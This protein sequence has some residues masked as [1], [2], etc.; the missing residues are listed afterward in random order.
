MNGTGSV[1]WTDSL[2][3]TTKNHNPSA[4]NDYVV[5]Q[6]YIL[7]SPA[8]KSFAFGGDSLTVSGDSQIKDK[9]ANN[10]T[11]TIPNL[12]VTGK[13]TIANGD[14][15]ALNKIAGAIDIREAGSLAFD[16]SFDNASGD[17]RKFEVQSDV[18]G[19]GSLCAVASDEVKSAGPY[20][21]FLGSLAGF[22]GKIAVRGR[23]AV[24]FAAIFASSLPGDPDGLTEDGLTVEGNSA[25]KF[26]TSGKLGIMRGVSLGSGA[27]EIYVAEGE[28]VQIDGFVTGSVGFRKTGKGTLALANV[29]PDLMGTVTVAEGTLQLCDVKETALPAADVTVAP[30]AVLDEHGPAVDHDPL[31]EATLT[32][33][34]VIADGQPHGPVLTVTDPTEGYQV[35]WSVDGG[36]YV[37]TRPTFTAPG[38]HTVFCR[39]SAT[40]YMARK[41]RTTVAIRA[42]RRIVATEAEKEDD[43]ADA[44]VAGDDAWSAIQ[45]VIDGC[46]VGDLVL[47]KA[48]TYLLTNELSF[49][50]SLPS[51]IILRSDDGAGNLAR[52]TTLFV[53]GYPATSNRLVRI[54]AP[55][56]VVDGFTLTNGF[57]DASC[58]GGAYLDSCGAGGGLRNCDVVCCT[59]WHEPFVKSNINNSKLGTG[60]GVYV[61]NTGCVSNCLIRGNT[62][63]AG[64][65]V[66]L[67]GTQ[68]RVFC[69]QSAAPRVTACTLV[70]NQI[71]GYGADNAFTGSA[72]A[73]FRTTFF[74]GSTIVSNFCNV[75][76]KGQFSTVGTSGGYLTISNCVFE[77]NHLGTWKTANLPVVGANNNNYIICVGTTFVREGTVGNVFNNS[78]EK[79]V[80][81]GNAMVDCLGS[82]GGSWKEY[83]NCLFCGNTNKLCLLGAVKAENCTFVNNLGAIF[84]SGGFKT[85]RIANCV[86][87]GNANDIYAVNADNA[88]NIVC[89][90]SNCCISATALDRRQG[91]NRSFALVATNGCNIIYEATKMKIGDLGFVAPSQRDFHLREGS[92]LLD[93]GMTL[94]WMDG[95]SDRDGKPRVVGLAPDIGCYERQ[96]GTIDPPVHFVRAVAT[97][98]DKKDE[99]ADAYVGLQAAA[100]AAYGETVYVKSGTYDVTEPVTVRSWGVSIVGEGPG[101][102]V[103]DGGLPARTN[104]IFTID[105]PNVTLK[106][107]TIQNGRANKADGG[108]VYVNA[109][110]F[111]MTNCVIRDCVGQNG[112]G[113]YAA[114]DCHGIADCVFSNNLST[115]YGAGAYF[116]MAATVKACDFLDGETK[117]EG[118]GCYCNNVYAFEDCVFSNNTTQTSGTNQK[119]GAFYSNGNY[120]GS[121]AGCFFLDNYA[122]EN[123]GACFPNGSCTFDDCQ[124][125]GNRCKDNDGAIHAGSVG[126]V[127]TVRGCYFSHNGGPS[128]PCVLAGGN[129]VVTNCVFENQTSTDSSGK[130]GII[131]R[132]ADNKGSVTRVIVTDCKFLNAYALYFVDEFTDVENCVFSNITAKTGIGKSTYAIRNSLFTDSPEPIRLASRTYENCTIVNNAGGAGVLKGDMP[133]LVNTVVAKSRPYTESNVRVSENFS[134]HKDWTANSIVLTNSVIVGGDDV[135]GPDGTTH[136][137]L[138]ALDE[139]GKSFSANPRFVDPV[140]GDWHLKSGS[141]LRDKALTL[142][143]MTDDATDLDGKPRRISS[144][145]KAYPDSLP[146]IGCYECDIPKPGFLLQVR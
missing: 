35:E 77:A 88:K 86:F 9:G 13:A 85:N 143:W 71:V 118:G 8:G 127:M 76:A 22:S 134:C 81:D 115:S 49:A 3:T 74:D 80:C 114:V 45:G 39:V 2:G 73:S 38:V 16:V 52:K 96:E 100:D 21:K 20:V 50:S 12:I 69:A 146:D 145:G 27:C 110:D 15:N 130:N 43:W 99:W 61:Y 11:V 53:G 33:V 10:S 131:G 112:G 7:R 94:D 68:E 140:N 65:G 64:G 120:L 29:S 91:T 63:F 32:G 89:L 119:G 60:G 108:G 34:D 36:A 28:T 14:A 111:A 1:G 26:E 142:D 83:R 24:Q 66:Y 44:T 132:A 90:I 126:N 87:Y 4:G 105:T 62:A 41:L 40:G 79:F 93:A 72:L 109:V 25:L 31:V 17:A 113:V 122:K 104:R 106:G 123:G 107:L 116:K 117:V 133:V 67:E 18:S 125:V 101:A 70:E 19:S 128:H 6:N 56:A 97:E 23:D 144:D 48:G 102:T 55:A 46:G 75:T 30:G 136:L 129:S 58:G 98:A 57:V 5:D 95:A 59:A 54:S 84:S 47:V 103:V 92:P 135:L 121:F 124:F 82:L 141:P 51:G 137:D 42:L 139:T 37:P 78:Y 138:L